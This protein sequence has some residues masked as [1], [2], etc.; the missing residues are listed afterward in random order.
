[1]AIMTRLRSASQASYAAHRWR[2]TAVSSRVLPHSL[3][4]RTYLIAQCGNDQAVLKVIPAGQAGKR[5][6]SAH[7]VEPCDRLGSVLDGHPPVGL[8]VNDIQRQVPQGV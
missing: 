3:E 7:G 5:D 8:T 1:M 2:W 6:G 4:P